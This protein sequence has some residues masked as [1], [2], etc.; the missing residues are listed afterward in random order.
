MDW[1]SRRRSCACWW[2]GVKHTFAFSKLQSQYLLVRP[3]WWKY[4]KSIKCYQ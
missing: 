1:D 3:G 2:L 4:R